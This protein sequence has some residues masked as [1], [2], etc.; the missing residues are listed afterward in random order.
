[1]SGSSTT[2]TTAQTVI[3]TAP[4]VHYTSSTEGQTFTVKPHDPSGR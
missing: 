2:A 1:M 3:V 4:N